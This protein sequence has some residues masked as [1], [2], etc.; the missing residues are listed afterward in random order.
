MLDIS[1]L[2]FKMQLVILADHSFLKFLWL[3]LN[4]L[5]CFIINLLVYLEYT[6]MAL[7]EGIFSGEAPKIY[8]NVI[9]ISL[10]NYTI[11]NNPKLRQVKVH[12]IVITYYRVKSTGELDSRR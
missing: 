6:H 11:R 5:P 3:V 10:H 4:F 2:V 7:T 12:T 9:I 1:I 8:N